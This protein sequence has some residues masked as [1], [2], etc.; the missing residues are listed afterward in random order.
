MSPVTNVWRQ[1]VERRLWPAAILLIAALV[2]VP[3]MLAKDPEPAATVPPANVDTNG[4]ELAN[5]PIVVPVTPA[6]RANRRKVLG[7][8]KNPFAS[9]KPA[10][11]VEDA[12]DDKG[13]VVVKTPTEGSSGGAGGDSGS[14]AGGG[15]S[16]ST[17][18]PTPTAPATPTTP[19]TPAPPK[20]TYEKHELT[21]RFGAEDTKRL[22]VKLLAPLPS[23][24][25]PV[26][27][28]TRLLKDG[29]TAEFLLDSGVEAMGDGVCHPSPEQCETIRLREGETEFLDV[30]D[31][32]GNAVGAVPARPDRDPQGQ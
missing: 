9:A 27:I 3:L 20:K 13:P 10:D 28:Y 22:S 4:G 17:G 26:L 2:A 16:P 25:E 23:A 14:S 11:P 32:T 30:K 1:L 18:G 21:V 12:G 29:K 8:A 24:E 5:T 19:A 6:D 7:D 15:T 31:E